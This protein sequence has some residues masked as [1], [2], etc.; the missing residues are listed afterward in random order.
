[1]SVFSII[2]FHLHLGGFILHLPKKANL[3]PTTTNA[4]MLAQGSSLLF[5]LLV[6]TIIPTPFL[7][8][9]N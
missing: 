3:N 8:V 6:V 2:L 7:S 5:S 4:C 9:P 1:M